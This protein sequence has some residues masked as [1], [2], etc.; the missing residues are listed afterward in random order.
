MTDDIVAT[1][2]VPPDP[3][4]IV[5]EVPGEQ[6]PEGPPG[7]DGAAGVGFRLPVGPAALGGHWVVRGSPSGVVFASSDAVADAAQ[8]LGVTAA[9]AVAGAPADIIRS[10]VMTETTWTWQ[11]GPLYLGLNG[12]MTQTAP[13]TGFVLQVATAISAT[14]VVVE[15]DEPFI[16]A[17]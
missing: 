5:V 11:P 9:A 14:T 6:G 4:V 1:V 8:V 12:L 2:E 7:R 15:I 3:D 13:S 17:A 16:L 10:G